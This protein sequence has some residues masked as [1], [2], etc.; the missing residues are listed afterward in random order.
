M[1][2]TFPRARNGRN[3]RDTAAG[4]PPAIGLVFDDASRTVVAAY[5]LIEG[6]AQHE[7]GVVRLPAAGGHVLAHGEELAGAA[8]GGI[9]VR[10][11]PTSF[12]ARTRVE[13]FGEAVREQE[14]HVVTQTLIQ[15]AQRPA[16][17]AEGGAEALA[18]DWTRLPS[19]DVAVTAI[20]RAEAD[21]ATGRASEWVS[22]AAGGQPCDGVT[23]EQETYLRAAAR[24]W[25]ETAAPSA[26]GD[27]HE[28]EAADEGVVAFLVVHA[29]GSCV[30][31]W[32][33][34]RGL[35]KE[36]EEPFMTVECEGVEEAAVEEAMAA[37]REAN[38]QHALSRVARLLSNAELEK[39]SVRA[40]QRLVWS[41]SDD[42]TA[43][44]SEQ[45]SR[46]VRMVK[47]PVEQISRNLE[48]AVAYGLVLG[49]DSGTLPAI[50]L[51]T[52]LAAR[53]DEALARVAAVAAAQ[54][55]SSR[56]RAVVL[57]L[58]P[59]AVALASLLGLLA[60]GYWTGLRLDAQ[61]EVASA[62][63]AR[64]R[65]IAEERRVATENIKWFDAVINQIFERR[66]R[67]GAAV[68]LFDDLNARYPAD[69]PT[70]YVRELTASSNGSV[71]IKGLTKR[72]QSVT[73]FARLL[74]FSNGL[75]GSGSV[76]TSIRSGSTPNAPGS[77]A[78]LASSGS[79]PPGVFEWTVRG[80]YTP[81][82]AEKTTPP[83]KG[84]QKQQQ[85]KQNAGAQAPP[86]QPVKPPIPAAALPQGGGAR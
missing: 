58:A 77:N 18:R 68:R 32:S 2:F 28:P 42:M 67:Q 71:E 40:V 37:L 27:A 64:L 44:V 21:Y 59:F 55:A 16:P 48:E 63:A 53:N 10:T 49:A 80:V 73:S 7:I 69:D 81:L 23:F 74:E 78:G 20:S 76:G 57:M 54:A 51:A 84:G 83:A 75:F 14:D 70:W 34:A 41:S 36:L 46:Y 26:G 22:A 1:S 19:R 86:P 60:V 43:A 25:L 72:E 61:Q 17:G 82:A 38:A 4:P 62:E 3:P 11:A 31:L 79:L 56:S 66:S 47:Y 35:F 12:G 39:E 8:F 65:P 13:L 9:P 29:Y 5:R 30:G 85:P 50:D 33:P 45:V 52:D 6:A 24:Y 15:T